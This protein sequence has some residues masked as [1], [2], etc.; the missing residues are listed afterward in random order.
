VRLETDATRRLLPVFVFDMSTQE[1][2]LLDG[3]R[4]S[5]AFEDMVIVVRLLPP[6]PLPP[7]GRCL[8][9]P[10]AAAA[11]LTEARAAALA[12]PARTAL[13]CR[14]WAGGWQRCVQ[15]IALAQA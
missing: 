7:R 8:A 10:L 1:P 9:S 5:V 12:H 3:W 6:P 15:D 2:L 4:Q 13:L 11:S 14:T